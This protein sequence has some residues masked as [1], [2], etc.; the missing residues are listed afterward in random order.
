[1][2]GT[3]HGLQRDLDAHERAARGCWRVIQSKGR[4]DG[5]LSLHIAWRHQAAIHRSSIL[6]AGPHEE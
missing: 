5:S 3:S 1:M 6:G 4:H 2:L